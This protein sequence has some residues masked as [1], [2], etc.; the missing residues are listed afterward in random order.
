MK[1]QNVIWELREDDFENTMTDMGVP[2]SQ[3]SYL[4]E[5]AKEKFN[6]PDWEEYI[7]AFIDEH[8]KHSK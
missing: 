8:M 2:S 6:I 7:Q 5:L 4:I 3:H 1:K